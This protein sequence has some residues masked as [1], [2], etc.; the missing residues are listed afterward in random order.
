MSNHTTA[1]KKIIKLSPAR[2]DAKIKC[3]NTISAIT[4]AKTILSTNHHDAYTYSIEHGG[5][6]RHYSAEYHKFIGINKA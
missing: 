4:L 6:I 5:F 1:M 2:P 3:E